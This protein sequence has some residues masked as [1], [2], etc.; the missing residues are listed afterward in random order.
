MKSDDWSLKDLYLDVEGKAGKYGLQCDPCV[1]EDI[2]EKH[3][4]TLRQKLIEDIVD[5]FYGHYPWDDNTTEPIRK[6]VTELINKRFGV[7]EHEK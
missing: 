5:K 2:I 1:I 7:D 6:E 3:L 4:E